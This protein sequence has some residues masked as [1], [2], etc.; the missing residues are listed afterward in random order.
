MKKLFMRMFFIF[1][2]IF[3]SSIIISH[4]AY[5]LY[6]IDISPSMVG[7]AYIV[8]WICLPEKW[9]NKINGK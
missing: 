4:F 3:V 5:K 7:I 8:I 6:L 9:I 2:L 1:L